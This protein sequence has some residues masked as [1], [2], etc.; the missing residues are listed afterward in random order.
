MTPNA[1]HGYSKNKPIKSIKLQSLRT[2][3]DTH[4]KPH[5]HI[6]PISHPLKHTL[7][8][9]LH[10]SNTMSS[11]STPTTSPSST[12]TS[13]TT[14]SPPQP[15]AK[16]HTFD[17]YHGFKESLK[18]A[19]EALIMQ[20]AANIRY[21]YGEEAAFRYEASQGVLHHLPSR[22][23][24][25]IDEYVSAL[26]RE[27]EEVRICS[28]VEDKVRGILESEDPQCVLD[29]MECEDEGERRVWG[30]GTRKLRERRSG[31]GSSV[32]VSRE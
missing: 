22:A 9:H 13:S 7:E 10:L 26:E 23:I 16:M 6:S 2:P 27:C 15:P 5:F 11:P 20:T 25:G 18:R 31:G 17:P 12:P 24:H 19:Q 1:N 3:R 30:L 21:L 28:E 8:P 4:H 29:S 32:R 14:S